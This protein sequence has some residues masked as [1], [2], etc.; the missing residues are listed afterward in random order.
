MTIGKKVKTSLASLKSVQ[1][2]M[3]SFALET[4]N[5]NA[6]QLFQQYA[7]QAQSMINSLES[8]LQ[9]I[10]MEEPQYKGS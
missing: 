5:H 3:E 6:K 7:Q 4:Q 10:E 9:E 8:R 1:A 2:D